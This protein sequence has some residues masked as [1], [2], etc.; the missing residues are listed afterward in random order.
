MPRPRVETGDEDWKLTSC[1]NW[2]KFLGATEL[3]T[4][5]IRNG[6]GW[7]YGA[8]EGE[9]LAF[10]NELLLRDRNI[11]KKTVDIICI[12]HKNGNLEREYGTVGCTKFKGH[13]VLE[14]KEDLRPKPSWQPMGPAATL[15]VQIDWLPVESY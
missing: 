11:D 7:K 15:G 4:D 1:G 5:W 14:F 10:E 2:L 13:I 9:D 12:S 3:H 6:N 8:N